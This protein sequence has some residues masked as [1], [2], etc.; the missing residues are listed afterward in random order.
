[1]IKERVTHCDFCGL[2]V[3]QAEKECPLCHYPLAPE[4]EER[5]LLSAIDDLQR[6]VTYGGANLR[7]IDLLSRYR[8]RLDAL[9][10]Q[11]AI[12]VPAP[13]APPVA[14]AP[15]VEAAPPPVIVPLTTQGEM[16]HELEAAV[17]ITRPHA[18]RRVFSWKA[19]L[20]DQAINIVASL[21]AFLILVGALGFTASTSNLVLA[22]FIVCTVH[23]VFGIT[24]FV[25]YRFASFRVVATIYTIIY[26]LLVPLVGFSAYRL[27]AGN[28]IALSVPVL[29][30]IASLYAAIVYTLLA[31][32]QRFPLFAYLGIVALA[33]ADMAVA[34]AL[35]LGFWWWLSLLMILAFPLLVSVQPSADRQWLFAGSRAVLREPMRILLYVFAGIC[36]LG[37][38]ASAG[39]SFLLDAASMPNTEVRFSILCLTVLVLLWSGL[40]LWRTRRTRFVIGL[41][42]LFLA[43]VLALCYALAF[44]AIGYALALT[45]VAL[46]YHGF[47][48]FAPHPLQPFGA[49]ERGLDWTALALVFLVPWISSPWIPVQLFANAYGLTWLGAYQT[50]WQ[51]VA[52]LVALAAGLVLVLSVTFKWAGLRRT[53][54]R[55]AWCWMLL[56]G[57]FLLDF[58]AALVIVGLNLVP[59]WSLFG[60]ILA[61]MAGAVI[62]RQRAGAAWANPLDIG[63]L[64]NIA[65]TLGLSG[66]QGQDAISAL[67]LFFAAATYGILLYQRRQDW[68]VVPFAFALLAVLTLQSRPEVMLVAG[69]ILPLAAIGIHRLVSEKW[70]EPY[71]KWL[72]TLRLAGVW[73][74]PLLA[75]ALLYGITIASNDIPSST[76]TIQSWLGVPCPVAL[77]LTLLALVWYGSAALA[78]VKV[79]LIP[80]AGFAIGAS[81]LPDNL[82]W[83]LVGLAPA[84]AILA[85]VTRRLAGRE[86]SLPLSLTALVCGVMAGYTG[87]MQDHLGAAAYVLLA[88]AVLAYG[89]GAVEDEIVPMWVAPFFALWSAVIAAGF[90]NDLYRPP[91][92]AI[93]AAT[94]GVGV[95]FFKL[96]PVPRIGAGRKHSFMTYSLPLYMTALIGAVLTGVFGSL[97]DINKPFYGAVPD[98]LLIY[99]VVAFAVLLYER[100][101][102]WLWL[103][104]G[105]VAWGTMLAVQLVP[106][107]VPLIGAGAA[108]AGLLVG[109]IIRPVPAK[110]ALPVPL[111]MQSLRQFTWSWP[112]YLLVLLA[113]MLTGVRATLPFEQAPGNFIAY[114]LLAFSAVALGIMLVERLPELL[115]FP[116]GLAAWA[117]WL[118]YPS[119]NVASMMIAYSGLCV[120][121]FASQIIWKAI[122]PE[123]HLLP[124]GSLHNLLGVGGQSVVVLVV[125]L[126]GGLFADSGTLV[127]VG[128]GSLFVLAALLFAY[129]WMRTHNVIPI[130]PLERDEKVATA[131]VKRAKQIQRW[132]YYGAGLLLS[133]VVSWE[134]SAFGQTRLDV[135]LLAPASYLAVDAPF[136]MRDKLISEHNMVGQVTAALGAALLLL[137]SLWFSFSDSNLLP[138]LILVG[139]ALALLALGIVTRVRIFILSSAALVVVGALRALFLSTPPSLALMLLG[140]V[141]LAIATALFVARR[142]LRS[143]WGKWE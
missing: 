49:L 11:Q 1:M 128:A 77:E 141:L 139:E 78:R 131:S 46:L 43:S 45:A 54:A 5:F 3:E 129:G 101:P 70:V 109:R 140:G 89:I 127:H 64:A 84:L 69:V 122:P 75:V 33:V 2:I 137:P 52:E 4:K 134:L 53:P 100:R 76:S 65:I 82:F 97:S 21:G 9:H 55:P 133:L 57:G 74:W 81:L 27:I 119:P 112:A 20:A 37:A 116:V 102:G 32:Y 63:V 130:V 15:R 42:F 28:Y 36:A 10:R 117:I 104:A 62:V 34:S 58:G 136:L 142:Q 123:K 95:S 143:V 99:G 44:A 107:Y 85:V 90:L 96:M 39:Y 126:Q 67:L 91:I 135:L 30:A 60:L 66:N 113:A 120:L 25:T 68:L 105:L 118:W 18:P 17:P 98:A 80:A 93:A 110:A 114:S 50:S 92:V 19:F 115:V 79:W 26:A 48:R 103:A 6:V 22:F 83:V 47:V 14:V 86:W 72:G 38:L 16:P 138:T 51:T 59:V 29:V 61:V 88:F 125:A 124:V 132:C 7:V 41:P 111:Q 108:G 40:F 23:A 13:A 71:A 73:E 94:L 106:I 121:V 12:A 35:T 87:G 24:G 8:S 56:L 31:I